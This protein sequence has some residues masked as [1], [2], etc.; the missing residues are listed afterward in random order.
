MGY[1]I[2]WPPGHPVGA[3]LP[4]VVM[5]HGEGGNHS[6]ALTGLRPSEA[7][8]IEVDGQ[9]IPP[10]ALATVDG[11]SGYWNPHPGDNPMGMV[12]DELIPMCQQLRL[13]LGHRKVG[14]M[15]ISMGGYGALLFAE[16]YPQAIGAVAAISPAIW[17]SY[18]E[19]ESVNGGAYSSAAAFAADDAV[20]HAGKLAD[21]PVRIASGFDDPFHPG[22]VALA[23]RIPQSAVVEFS[24][25]CHTGGF[26][27]AQE[28]PS[29]KFLAHHL[30]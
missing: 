6:N 21:T 11:G 18:A 22:V 7:V 20:T 29:L 15:G 12:M 1:T 13:G 5:L 28:P 9:P 3:A 27:E 8:A 17:T 26:F 10:V 24:K 4:L 19:A 2:A 14:T 16:K 23:D 25:G 30:T